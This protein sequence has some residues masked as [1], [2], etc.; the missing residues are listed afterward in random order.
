MDNIILSLLSYFRFDGIVP[1]LEEGAIE[2]GTTVTLRDAAVRIFDMWGKENLPMKMAIQSKDAPLMLEKAAESERFGN[3]LLAGYVDHLDPAAEKQFSGL[4]FIFEGEKKQE[5]Y[6]AFRGTDSTLV[7]WK[8]DFNMSFK[9]AVPAQLEA[10]VYVQ[11]V[12]AR[13]KGVLRIGGH[14]KGGNLAA[15]AAA[16]CGSGIQKRITAVYRND[17]PGFNAETIAR[18]G[19]QAIKSKIMSFIPESSV[20][21]ML[22]EHDDSYIVVKSEQ[23]GLLQHD[24]YS[25]EVSRDNMVR[26]DTVNAG[27]RFI[28]L[29]LKEWING[30][31]SDQIEH[32]VDGFYDIVSST[33]VN[34]LQELSEQWL[35]HAGSILHSLHTMDAET[36]TILNE[37]IHALFK[38]ARN[39][40]SSLLPP[41]PV[42]APPSPEESQESVPRSAPM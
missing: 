19:Y 41:K 35:K 2:S 15:Y 6:I 16:F 18:Q 8:E 25:W 20:V 14:S 28:D 7:G 34:S 3:M 17:A 42:S 9:A 13:F 33:K 11:A 32:F 39:N 5:A 30:L 40:L 1:V 27:S 29:T 21:G 37:T 12:A 23:T 10:A 24:A 4:T 38:A 22:F 31:N 36:K 26:V